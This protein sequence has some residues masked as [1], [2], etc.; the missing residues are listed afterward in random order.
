MQIAVTPWLARFLS[1]PSPSLIDRSF[2][3][4]HHLL[5]CNSPRDITIDSFLR[6]IL[7][8]LLI[9]YFTFYKE[10]PLRELASE[11]ERY[12]Q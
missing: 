5:A 12:P 2:V 9:L 7:S 10:T 4:R 11:L 1:L 6:F 3:L 8:I